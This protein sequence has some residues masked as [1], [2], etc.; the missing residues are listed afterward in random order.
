MATKFSYVKPNKYAKKSGNGEW[1][2][3]VFSVIFIVGVLGGVGYYMYTKP[4]SADVATLCPAEGPLGH[5]VVLVDNTDPYSFI[6]REAFLQALDSLSDEVVP[7]GHLLSVFS[8]GE[9]FQKNAEPVFEKCNPGSSAGKSELTAN[10]KRIDKRFNESFR[11][12]VL[13]LEDV[14]MAKEPA[15]YS[16]VFE[17]IQL[18]SIKGFRAQNV[19]GARTLII[20]SDMLP[21]TP[22]F[23]MFKGVPDYKSFSSSSYGERSKTDLTGVKVELHYLMKYPKLQTMKQLNFW[24]QYFEDTGARLARVQTMEG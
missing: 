5:V 11:E 6:Q 21:N 17:M 19:K 20:F 23:S 12:P 1:F 4:K 10:L 15:K 18:A 8:L 24:E 16:P 9:D 13:K 14:L 3:I 2:K 7:E 22:D